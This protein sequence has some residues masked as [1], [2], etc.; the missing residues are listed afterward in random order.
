[1]PVFGWI[2]LRAILERLDRIIA[3]LE[4]GQGLSKEDRH[5]LDKSVQRLEKLAAER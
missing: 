5:R 2:G 4:Q 1:M 3:L